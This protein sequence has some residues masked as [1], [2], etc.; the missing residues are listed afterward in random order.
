MHLCWWPPFQ[1]HWQAEYYHWEVGKFQTVEKL[2]GE[3]DDCFPFG[4][5]LG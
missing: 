3:I 2:F 4:L 5:S 1:P